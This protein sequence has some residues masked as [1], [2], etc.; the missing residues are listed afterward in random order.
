MDLQVAVDAQVRRSAGLEMD[1][2]RALADH[3]AQQV[4]DA[5]AAGAPVGHGRT[6][7]VGY[8]DVTV[9]GP[10]GRRSLLALFAMPQSRE[11]PAP[12]L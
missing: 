2:G 6:L 8:C 7:E 9:D 10:Y 1:V 12:R 3:D 11:R 4:G 5:D